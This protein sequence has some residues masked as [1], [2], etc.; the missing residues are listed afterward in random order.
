M[1]KRRFFVKIHEEFLCFLIT[2]CTGPSGTDF[3]IF[4]ASKCRSPTRG[5]PL[6][7]RI[8]SPASIVPA[9]SAAP[10]VR[11]VQSEGLVPAQLKTD[12]SKLNS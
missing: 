11:K 1:E 10:P 2:N 4:H 5:F 9:C 6:I 8:S 3:M 12:M 7:A